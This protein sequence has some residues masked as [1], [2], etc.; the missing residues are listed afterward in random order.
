M[1]VLLLILTLLYIGGVGYW[2][3]KKID[4]FTKSGNIHSAWDSGSEKD[5]KK[6][7]QCSLHCSLK[8]S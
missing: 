2:I 5:S 7:E 8:E 6:K 1:T 4:N 3:M